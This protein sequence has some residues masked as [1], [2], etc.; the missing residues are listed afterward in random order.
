ML[1]I[2]VTVI[3]V[4]G[5]LINL[6]GIVADSSEPGEGVTSASQ[7]YNPAG[8]WKRGDNKLFTMISP[9]GPPGSGRYSFISQ[10]K[11]MGPTFYGIFPTAVAL[12]DMYGEAIKTG[13]NTYDFTV[14]DYAINA[15]YGVVYF[16]LWSGTIV[17]TSKDTLD[18]TFYASIYNSTQDPFGDEDPEFGCWG[19]WSFTYERIPVVPPC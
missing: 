19:P 3:P 17:Q 15:S 4:A 7:W 13:K 6:R 9:A 5:N 12:S 1:L 14:I 16:R 11:D 18:G 8:A 2:A 10:G